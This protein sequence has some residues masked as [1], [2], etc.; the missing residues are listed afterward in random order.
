MNKNIRLISIVVCLIYIFMLFP[1]MFVHAADSKAYSDGYGNGLWDGMDAAYDDLVDLNRKNYS[2]VMPKDNEI[3]SYYDL[4]KETS[5][6]T[7]DFIKG[8]KEGFREG[9]NTTYD[10]PKFDVVDLNYDEL[11]GYE[12][13]KAAGYSDFYANKNNRWANSVPGATKI[14][15]IFG[16]G[17]ETNSYKNKFIKNFKS[18]YQEGYEIAYR[19]AKYEPFLNSFER[20]E[21]DG[22]QIG[23]LLGANYGSKDYFDKMSIKWDRNMLTDSEIIKTFSLDKDVEDYQKSFLASYKKAYREEYEEAYRNANLEYHYLCYKNGYDTGKNLGIAKGASNAKTD[24]LMGKPNSIDKYSFTEKNLSDEYNLH[25]ETKG[26]RDGFI[27][28]FKQGFSEGY[29]E[30]YQM[31]LYASFSEKIAEEIIPIGGNQIISGDNKIL[32][33]V[34]NGTFY[35]DVMLTIDKYMQEKDTFDLPGKEVFTKNSDLYLLKISN[36]YDRYNNDNKIEVSFEYYGGAKGGVYRYQ[37]GS[38]YYLPTK[39][40]ENSITAYLSPKL[41]QE[42]AAY[43][44]FIDEKCIIPLDTRGH[45][46]RDEVITTLRR[47]YT[48]LYNDNTFRPDASLTKAQLILYLGRANRWKMDLSD[49]DLKKVESLKDYKS[50]ETIK[51]LVAYCLKEGYL[52]VSK[53][54]KINPNSNISYSELEGIIKKVYNNDD[55][56]WKW[57]SDKMA[58]IKDKRSG[59]LDSMNNK[60]TRAEFS[61]MLNLLDEFY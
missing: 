61:Y 10:N 22:E 28:G 51:G 55:F 33:A 46:A 39:I 6:Y 43:G 27:G 23:G 18:Q 9:Y 25:K 58:V 14:V 40:S 49:S 13:G 60:V 57:V 52:D 30:T 2:K 3:K 16:L 21:K 26:Y 53:D 56:T 11:I 45:W 4:D 19:E 34:N 1:S 38:W 31:T 8:Y 37:Y 12:M 32:V 42:N 47:G 24:Y 35:N 50:I 48:G 59:S 36:P 54:N 41:A 17:K 15:Q 20:G 7:R 29:I 5:A 44:V